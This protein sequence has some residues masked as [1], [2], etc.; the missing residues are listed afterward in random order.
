MIAGSTPN[1]GFRYNAAR[2]GYEVD[3]ATMPT[4][5]RIFRMVGVEGA[6]LHAV[7]RP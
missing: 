3:E 6:S 2:D 5:R 4:V 7:Q 1:F